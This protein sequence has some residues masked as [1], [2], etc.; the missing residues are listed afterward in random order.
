[1]AEIHELLVWWDDPEDSPDRGKQLFPSMAA[2]VPSA[3]R[4]RGG[5]DPDLPGTAAIAGF[6][7]VDLRLAQDRSGELYVLS[8]SDGMI[9]QIRAA[10][11]GTTAQTHATA[12][13]PLIS[14][15]A[16]TPTFSRRRILASSRVSRS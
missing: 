6:G 1:M 10:V 16:V 8:K 11:L 2:I 13:Q 4:A 9:R 15:F 12:Q 5:K 3:Y 7:L 14:N